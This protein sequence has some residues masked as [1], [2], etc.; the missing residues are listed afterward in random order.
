[1]SSG[2][3]SVSEED[4]GP[5][6]SDVFQ[7]PGKTGKPAPEDR[8]DVEVKKESIVHD[9]SRQPRR[10][11]RRVLDE[12]DDDYGSFSENE[13]EKVEEK[14]PK[15]AAATTTTSSSSSRTAK[16]KKEKK[17]VFDTTDFDSIPLSQLIR[18][19]RAAAM[20]S[21]K[22]SQEVVKQE[23]MSDVDEDYE[24]DEEEEEKPKRRGKGAGK[25]AKKPVKR[26]RQE[27]SKGKSGIKKE[28]AEPAMK[29]RKVSEKAKPNGKT[30]TPATPTKRKAKEIVKK[31]PTVKKEGKGKRGTPSDPFDILRQILEENPIRAWWREDQQGAAS[32]EDASIKWNT[33]E[34][35][36]VL[37]PP[38]YEPHGI[39][40]LYDGKPVTLT[41]E[42]EEIATFYAGFHDS[43]YREKKVFLDNFWNDW[44]KVLGKGHVIKSLALCDFGPIEH[45][46]QV[47]KEKKRMMTKEEKLEMKKEREKLEAPFREAV[48]D[49][50]I[51]LVGNFRAEPPGLFRGRGEH[52]KMGCLKRRIQPEDVTINIG[53]DAEVPQPPPGHEW[54]EVVHNRTVTW[55]AYWR[56]DILG[57]YKYVFLS[58]SS[59]FKTKSDYEKFETA[60]RLKKIIG[61]IRKDYMK[62]LKSKDERVRQRATAMYFIDKLALRVGNEK[63]DDEADTVGCCSL[64]V[65]HI[66]LV[67]GD[68]EKKIVRFDFLGKDS[69]RYLNECEVV[70]EVYKNLV[71]FTGKKDPSDE[72]FHLITP[73]VLNQ[74]FKS[75][76]PDLTA[77]VFRT[78]NASF[79]LDELV[80]NADFSKTSTLESKLLYYTNA[81]RDVAI[82][83]NHQKTVS[84]SHD[85]MVEKMQRMIGEEEILLKSLKKVVAA[86]RKQGAEEAEKIWDKMESDREKRWTKN[87]KAQLKDI[88]AKKK[89][90]E[91]RM[92]SLGLNPKSKESQVALQSEIKRIERLEAS[93]FKARRFPKSEERLKSMIAKAKERV[94]KKEVNLRIKDETKTVALGT[95]KI[96]YLDPRIT[97]AFCRRHNVPPQKFFSPSLMRKFPWALEVSADWRF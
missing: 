50:H 71:K 25:V 8:M 88:K 66:Q 53:E 52:P 93:V 94:S 24:E 90:K 34:H 6:L 32:T 43:P 49:G 35:N 40:I 76:M 38:E 17:T 96:N 19:P 70:P 59:A 60:R 64:R 46:L 20:A 27:K 2:S 51:E 45:Y 68:E 29:K 42:Q 83:C 62:E 48:V 67:E 54:K 77:K 63:D 92:K 12:D 13:E 81:N 84:K 86:L 61:R 44:K 78:Y 7:R 16:V 21:R 85:V 10:R 80:Q 89:E 18:N 31:E 4:S 28:K 91:E 39:K 30:K 15:T 69:I 36:G 41:P 82:L 74:H 73:S 5:T 95:S 57:A 58:S 22:K 87:I 65:E 33:L 11:G 75:Y 3:S 97:I 9:A 37:F 79:L 72:L 26:E 1:M 14:L 56:D 55:L 47:E 23:A